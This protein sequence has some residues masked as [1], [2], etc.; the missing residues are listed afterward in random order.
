MNT[1]VKN[2]VIENFKGFESLKVSNLKRVNLI[3]GKNNIG[4]TAFMEALRWNL[5]SVDS[6]DVA[7]GFVQL[8]RS[9]QRF[10]DRGSNSEYEIDLFHQDKKSLKIAIDNNHLEIQ[11]LDDIV[12]VIDKNS[13]EIRFL[14]SKEFELF[15]IDE[16]LDDIS[17]EPG[18]KFSLNADHRIYPLDSVMRRT[19]FRR[20]YESSKNRNI[21]FISSA[22]TDEQEIAVL[23]GHL[24][25]LNRE[26]YLNQSL[27]LFD[28][29]ILAMKQVVTDR[30]TVVLKL[31][32]KS[33]EKPILLS[34]LGEGVNRY[35]AILCGIWASR[36]G[37][38]FIDEIENGIH[39]TNYPK[40]WKIVFEASKLANCQ[41]FISTHSKEC[42]EKFNEANVE[43]EGVYLE[44]Y[45]NKKT[46]LI[47]TRE[48]SYEQLNY[49]LNHNGRLRGE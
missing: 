26:M 43:D 15:S 28:E 33:Q 12:S 8:L 22:T 40:L 7:Y 25:N 23:Y 37:Y 4:K 21:N 35:I 2:V 39:F 14:N 13:R 20:R 45:R 42:L 49:A 44:F 19:A 17:H 34:S 47:E 10:G 32:V 9:R 6:G 31:Q 5:S 30:N 11:D 1:L 24:I 36:D 27:S 16:D 41:L 3:G 48:R 46:Q 29:Q 38:L 18:M